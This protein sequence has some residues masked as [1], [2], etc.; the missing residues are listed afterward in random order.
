LSNQ[1]AHGHALVVAIANYPKVSPLP[2]TVLN[3]GIDVAKVLKSTDYC[4][5]SPDNVRVLMDER[6]TATAIRHELEN[7]AGIASDRD[8][9][10]VFFSGHGGRVEDGPDRGSYL[11]PFDCDASR[12]RQTAIDS[13][14]LT[15]RLAAIKAGRLVVLL[16]ACHSG[17]TGEVKAVVPRD[18]MKAG[19]DPAA[20][21]ALAQGVGRV[22]MASS[23]PDEVSLVLR[24]MRNS[25]FTHY[26][27]EGLRGASPTFNDGLIRIFELFR[28]VS[29]EVPKRAAQ[30]PIFKASDLENDFPVALY[31][32]G[33]RPSTS[34]VFANAGRDKLSPEAKLA[35]IDRLGDS[36]QRLAVYLGIPPSDKDRFPKGD[37]ALKILEWAELRKRTSRIRDALNYIGRDDLIEELDRAAGS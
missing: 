2:T 32:G 35:I 9:V 6:A 27:V 34:A 18:G 25:L 16:D 15:E 11:V 4:G 17:G 33:K 29:E 20:F 30:H 23:R 10:I 12:F 3:D 22:I 31:A 37:E 24:D 5:Y 8:T 19:L 26:L 36:W 13:V 21:D 14:E 28:Y 1:F 7:L